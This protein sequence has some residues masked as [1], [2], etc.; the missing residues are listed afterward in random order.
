MK[1]VTAVLALLLLPFCWGKPRYGM[2]LLLGTQVIFLGDSLELDP[3]KFVYGALFVLLMLAWLP[4][5]WHTRRLW[6]RHPV[7]KWLL[8]VFGVI[9]VSRWV[10]AVHGIPTVDWIRDLSPML[11]YSWIFLGIYTFGPEVNLRKYAKVLLA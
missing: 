1:L 3:E 2:L 6:I 9:L 4:G 8:A 10:G 5:F 7:A 11:N